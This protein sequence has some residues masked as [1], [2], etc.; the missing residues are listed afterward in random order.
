MNARFAGIVLVVSGLL[1]F[2]GTLGI[3]TRDLL[4]VLVG[5]G[6]ML[7]YTF[8]GYRTGFLVMGSCLSAVGIYT[9]TASYCVSWMRGPLLFLL[10]GLAFALVYLVEAVMGRSSRWPLFPATGFLLA[11]AL[12][13]ASRSAHVALDVVLWKY[14]P[15][16]LM[17][18][19]LWLI[20]VPARR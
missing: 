15:V 14:W 17:M 13:F 8:S 7:C 3:V 12:L 16:L 5:A 6:L 19:G 1:I 20:L 18:L 11:F 2:A 10:L 9:G 4:L